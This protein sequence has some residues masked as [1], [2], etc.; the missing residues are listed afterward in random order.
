MD[1]FKTKYQAMS[2]DDLLS[3]QVF[4]E[5]LIIEDPVTQADMIN[6]LM[7]RA[8]ELHIK[9]A[10]IRKMQA[11]KRLTQ[12]AN[13]KQDSMRSSS[14]AIPK[15]DAFSGNTDSE[16]IRKRLIEL[17]AEAYE[18]NDKG[19][20]RLF[21]DVSGDRLRYNVTSKE[22]NYYDGKRWIEDT[23]GMYASMY[24]KLL[25]D[26]LLFY[27]VNNIPEQ[28]RIQFTKYV[29]NLGRMSARRTMIEDSRDINFVN[30]DML[31]ADHFLT[32][33]QNVV[34]DF[35][36]GSPEVKA[37]SPDMLLTRIC[38]ASYDPDIRSELW[39]KTIYEVMEGNEAKM[40]YMQ[41][42]LGRTL[43]GETCEEE[44][45]FFH[46]ATTRNGKSTVLET[47]AYVLGGSEG[48]A[49]TIKPESLAVKHNADG[50]QASGDIARLKGARMLI[51]PE[52]PKRMLLD[53]ELL[54]QLTG[55]DTITARHLHQ[56]EIQFKP[57]FKLFV[58]TNHLP[59]VGDDTIFASDRIRVLEFNRHFEPHEQDKE[60]KSKLIEPDNMSGILNWLIE[61]Y[62]LYRQ[63]GLEPPEEVKQA[64]ANYRQNSD[65]L[66]T[67]IA[68]VLREDP[69]TSTK[70]G[71]I[72]TAYAN[73]C[74]SNGY[75]TES[76]GSFFQDL[77]DKDLLATTGTIDGK[78]IKNVV[79]GYYIDTEFGDSEGTKVPFDEQQEDTKR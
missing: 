77:R 74:S 39:E 33:T 2:K 54:K 41:K 25:A 57:E 37:H 48:Y 78:T 19:A 26:E 32:N 22:W 63:E 53:V 10:V 31:D 34:L 50:R 69:K 59:V 15:I 72:Y 47:V 9:S 11:Y 16:F 28:S 56:R 4:E 52:P 44:F 71:D 66:G 3:D 46:G 79:R 36:G 29:C 24:G 20:G 55:R 7:F 17:H 18:Q 38:N 64:V 75:C 45:L 62:L 23:G 60:L 21:A 70:A 14:V 8:K 76:K 73:W 5:I 58:N 1:E 30:A 49:M 68:E 42:A 27:A 51:S 43:T 35:R 13:A 40:R 12:S 65:K 67:F 6:A 61:G